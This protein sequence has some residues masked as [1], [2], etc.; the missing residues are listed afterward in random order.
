MSIFI[1]FV[2]VGVLFEGAISL[3]VSLN[4][5]YTYTTACYTGII[6]YLKAHSKIWDNF[7]QLQAL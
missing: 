4:L 6:V 5:T 7:W 2:S 3:W 1:L